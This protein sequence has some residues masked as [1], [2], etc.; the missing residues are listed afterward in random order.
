MGP[1]GHIQA[2]FSVDVYIPN[3]DS[4]VRPRGVCVVVAAADASDADR[5]RHHQ[6]VL[7]NSILRFPSLPTCPLLSL[8]PHAGMRVC[9]DRL[10]AGCGLG[11]Q[12]RACEGLHPE[13]DGQGRRGTLSW[14]R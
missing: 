4:Q 14:A 7:H 12:H 8:D 9:A 10:R 3:Q 2:N 6:N 5:Q 13:V 11:P 1:T